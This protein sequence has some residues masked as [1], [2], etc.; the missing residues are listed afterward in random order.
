LEQTMRWAHVAEFG[1]TTIGVV[2]GARGGGVWGAV[3]GGVITFG[4]SYLYLNHLEIAAEAAITNHYRDCLG[5]CNPEL[6]C[7]LRPSG[8]VPAGN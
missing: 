5:Q 4:A 8:P 2:I 1:L 7:P 3:A 6:A